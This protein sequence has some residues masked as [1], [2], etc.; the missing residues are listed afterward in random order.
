ML[1]KMMSVSMWRA[2]NKLYVHGS[3]GWG[4]KIIKMLLKLKLDE[5]YEWQ[6]SLMKLMI[7]H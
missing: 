4:T 2:A 3:E 5:D 7:S 1:T 6:S